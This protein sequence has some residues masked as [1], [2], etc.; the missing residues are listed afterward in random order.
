MSSNTIN[1]FTGEKF[2]FKELPNEKPK[3]GSSRKALPEKY[4]QLFSNKQI[5]C[6]EY[7]D[8]TDNDE[9]EI[10]QVRRILGSL[11]QNET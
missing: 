1:R 8:I 9:R 7:Q 4:K 11:D 2:W 6:V 10:F 3:R 5:V